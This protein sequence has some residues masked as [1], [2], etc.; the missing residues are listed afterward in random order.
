MLLKTPVGRDFTLVTAAGVLFKVHSTMLIGGPKALE[1]G[2]FPG[3][4]TQQDPPAHVNLPPHHHP[5][6]VDRAVTFLYTSDYQFDPIS[7]TSDELKPVNFSFYNATFVP[8]DSPPSP[9]VAAM[10]GVRK[11]I[12][13]LCMYALAE[14]LV[15]PALKASAYDVLTHLFV[16][17][18]GMSVLTLKSA[19]EAAFAPPGDAARICKDE[20]GAIQNAIVASVITH[21][22]KNWSEKNRQEFVQLLQDPGYA[23]FWSAYNTA[24]AESDDL[25]K[26]G[27]LAKDLAEKRAKAAEERK[28][29]RKLARETGAALSSSVPI[30]GTPSKTAGIKKVRKR[31]A[32]QKSEAQ[33]KAKDADDEAG[34]DG[35]VEMEF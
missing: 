13:H 15:Y 24:K 22:A 30:D 26:L 20:D 10:L 21:E 34:Q 7:N 6:L 28:A 31:A 17:R 3:G 35:D 16:I 18:R 11:H 1:D 19:I 12:F 14:E 27:K 23:P 9:A 33:T 32:K 4:L 25:I 2:I 5:I 8:A 29:A